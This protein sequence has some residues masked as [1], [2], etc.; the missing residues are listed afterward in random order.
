MAFRSRQA[1]QVF[2]HHQDLQLERVLWEEMVSRNFSVA[3]SLLAG[4]DRAALV[5]LSRR[6]PPLLPL[7]LPRTLPVHMRTASRHPDCWQHCL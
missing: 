3:I 6:S 5:G 4:L 7:D 1:W 2:A